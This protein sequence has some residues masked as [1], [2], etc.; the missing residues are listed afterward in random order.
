MM[1]D[2]IRVDGY[3][4][5]LRQAVRPGCIV[6]DIGTGCGIFALLASKFG[7]ARVYAVDPGEAIEVARQ[8]A[9]ANGVS[10][11][12][13]F[14]RDLSTRISLPERVDIIVSNI[15]GVLPFFE[16]HLPSIIDA[17]RRHLKPEGTLI[18][19]EDRLFAAIVEA[20]EV[21]GR[22]V[23]PWEQNRFGL[24]LSQARQFMTNSW[25]KQRMSAAQLLAP[26]AAVCKLDYR[27]LE[28]T[29][30]S[31]ELSWTA[32]R[33]GTAHGISAWFES[34]LTQ[35]ISFSTSPAAPETV[36]GGAFFPFEKPL[37]LACGDEVSVRLRAVLTGDDYVWCWDTIA[38]AAGSNKR[39]ASFEQS[40]F[41][42]EATSSADL[43][44]AAALTSTSGQ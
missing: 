32:E 38:T 27:T 26:P 20:P 35:S 15:G 40:T 29:G 4:E 28:N 12:I 33:N 25:I 42:A 31:A 21:Y 10:N 13:V 5:A 44:R 22:H 24:D 34:V 17:R 7:A 36:F 19:L 3:A 39:M 6:L 1:A 14:I 30:C 11:R 43:H 2:Q 37:K 16:Q 23:A 18:P 9:Q 41:F 8:L